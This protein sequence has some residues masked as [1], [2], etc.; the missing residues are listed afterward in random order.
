MKGRDALREMLSGGSKPAATTTGVVTPKRAAGAIRAMSAELQE[1]SDEA[2]AARSLRQTLAAGEQVVEIDPADVEASFVADRIS[3]ERDPGFEE[4]KASI[5][6]NGQQVPILVR[7]HP[8]QRTRYQIAYGRRRLRATRDLGMPVKAIIRHLSDRDL[9]IAQAQ[10]N[11]PRLDLSF[12]ERALFAANLN[13][14][15][16]DRDTITTALDVDKPELSR[17]LTVA[18]AVTAPLIIAIGPAPKIGRPRWLALVQRITQAGAKA[19]AEK[20]VASDAFKTAGTDARFNLV[21]SA[22][23][24]PSAKSAQKVAV[25]TAAGCRVAW[26]ER[27]R[28]GFRLFSDEP[29]FASFIENRLPDLLHEFETAASMSA[30]RQKGGS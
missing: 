16:F 23:A 21:L 18:D 20:V 17:L 28:N 4:L 14:H 15:G 27:T 12:I 2:A 10:E 7:P 29:A 25:S 9:V 19:R 8:E 5:A 24:P 13:A 30:D 1:L 6:A 26:L 11:W 22:L 3:T